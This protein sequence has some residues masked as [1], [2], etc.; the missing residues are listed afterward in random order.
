M[1]AMALVD[2]SGVR[3]LVG[4]VVVEERSEYRTENLAEEEPGLYTVTGAMKPD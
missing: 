2:R 4:G 1:G 3:I